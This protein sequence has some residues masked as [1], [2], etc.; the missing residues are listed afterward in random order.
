MNGALKITFGKRLPTEKK[1]TA[2]M[3]GHDLTFTAFPGLEM[4][5][6]KNLRGFVRLSGLIV[7]RAEFDAQIITQSHKM[8]I[9]FQSL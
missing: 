5:F 1:V 7:K 8:R 6:G 9:F 2:D 4:P 3:L